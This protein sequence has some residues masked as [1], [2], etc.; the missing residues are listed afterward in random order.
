MP[1]KALL[2]LLLVGDS[3]VGKS[4]IL[5]RYAD[6]TFT[7]VYTGTIGVDFKLKKI[8]KRGEELTLQIWDTAGQERFKSLVRSFYNG[9]NGVV[10]VFDLSNR[11][12][13]EAI[14][15]WMSEIR[16]NCDE[17][18]RILVGNKVDGP[19]SVSQA[20][21]EQI[22]AKYG[23]QYIETSAKTNLRIEETFEKL[24]D[25]IMIQRKPKTPRT[26]N[27]KIYPGKKQK[28]KKKTKPAKCSLN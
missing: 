7:D 12:S 23:L 20:E 14:R 25:Q 17:I 15:R 6:N 11:T 19:R 5:I 21:G 18:P 27:D 24:T 28:R 22:A 2:K 26:D 16:E 10:V 13:F 8:Y 9:A 1:E 4:A 3:G